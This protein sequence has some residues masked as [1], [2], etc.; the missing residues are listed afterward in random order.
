MKLSQLVNSALEDAEAKVASA[1]DAEKIAGF[2]TNLGEALTKDTIAG[3]KPGFIT[4]AAEGIGK[5]LGGTSRDS[6]VGRGLMALGAAGT[7]AAAGTAGAAGLATG[8]AIGGG[9]ALSQRKKRRQA[10]AALAEE[11][12]KGEKQSSDAMDTAVEAMKFAES[13]EHLA[14]LFPKI[15]DGSTQINDINGPETYVSPD[16]GVTRDSQTKAHSLSAQQAR[17]GGGSGSDMDIETPAPVGAKQAAEAVLSAKIAQSEALLA[18]GQAKLAGALLQQATAEFEMAKVALSRSKREAAQESFDKLS[19][20]DRREA[21]GKAPTKTTGLRGALPDWMQRSGVAT[22]GQQRRERAEAR[23]TGTLSKGLAKQIHKQNKHAY[24][25][26]ASTPHGNFITL[27]TNVSVSGVAPDNAGMAS[28]TKRDGK[29]REIA[30]LGQHVREPAF[31]ASADHGIQDNFEHV[32][33]AKIALFELI[34]PKV[35]AGYRDAAAERNDAQRQWETMGRGAKIVH[36]G[37]HGAL[38]GGVAGGA[39]GTIAGGTVGALKGNHSLKEGLTRAAIGALAGGAI[40]TGAGAA[41]GGGVGTAASFANT[42]MMRKRQLALS[43]ATN[44][45]TLKA[46]EFARKKEED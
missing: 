23:E 5:H 18:A 8:G 27:P 10:E 40:G 33:G 6:H 41:V 42:P 4:R 19:P 7:A 11:R 14:M 16:K 45:G 20:D 21:L 13:L 30:P 15:A 44:K 22:I 35:A 31:S 32:Q 29:S 39:L 34:F 9:A 43:H 46:D 26:A 12:S 1:R 25:E 2:A 17:T 28:F 36:H 37:G 24:D 38:R 3:V